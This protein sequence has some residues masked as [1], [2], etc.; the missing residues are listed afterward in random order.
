MRKVF[1]AGRLNAALHV[2]RIYTAALKWTLKR[3]GNSF[4]NANTELNFVVV[5]VTNLS[6]FY[7]VLC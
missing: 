1:P 2:A 7:G 4:Y 6:D 5:F 3:Q